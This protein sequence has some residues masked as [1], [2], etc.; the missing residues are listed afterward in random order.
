MLAEGL[1]KKKKKKQES[2]FAFQMCGFFAD[3]V[4]TSQN[5]RAEAGEASQ[6]VTEMG[7]FP[8]AVD[9]P[10]SLPNPCVFWESESCSLNFFLKR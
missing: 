5:Q 9:G 4:D 6:L 8:W 7:A 10:H 3:W 2:S 1:G